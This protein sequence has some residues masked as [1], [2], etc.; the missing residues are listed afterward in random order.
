M[1]LRAEA[2]AVAEGC[3]PS[4]VDTPRQ[5]AEVAARGTEAAARGTEAAAREAEAAAREAE[6]A[7]REAAEAAEEAGREKAAAKVQAVGRGA[8]A[9]KTMAQQKAAAATVQAA[10]R[11]SARARRQLSA[12]FEAS[13]SPGY[14]RAVSAHDKVVLG[15]GLLENS[16]PDAPP[17]PHRA[18]IG[19]GQILSSGASM[20]NVFPSPPAHRH[21]KPLAQQRRGWGKLS[22]QNSSW[23]KLSPQRPALR[24]SAYATHSSSLQRIN[25]A[26]NSVEVAT[27]SKA[28]EAATAAEANVVAGAAAVAE[29]ATVAGTGDAPGDAAADVTQRP[30]AGEEGGRGGGRYTMA[31]GRPSALGRL[32][33]E[34]HA[35]E[36]RGDNQRR[37]GRPWSED[38]TKVEDGALEHRGDNQRRE[39]GALERAAGAATLAG[40]AFFPAIFL[41]SSA[42]C[43]PPPSPSCDELVPMTDETLAPRH[44][45]MSS[46]SNLRHAEMSSSPELDLGPDLDLRHAEMSSPSDLRYAEMSSLAEKVVLELARSE[47]LTLTLPLPLPLTRWC[48]SSPGVRGCDRSCSSTRPRRRVVAIY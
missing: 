23:G 15:S 29:A 46:P 45:E 40:G 31:E 32:W 3:W 9:R 1:V 39:D 33:S 35:L 38:C 12:A 16:F 27:A 30:S 42:R 5:K 19:L 17:T 36:H 10:V 44:A 4:L 25:Y 43:S 37:E 11:G 22:P 47:R 26:V 21:E 28:A 7:A 48:S 41:A 34:D 20:S 14:S 24:K 8:S 18:S 13:S 6:A 2:E